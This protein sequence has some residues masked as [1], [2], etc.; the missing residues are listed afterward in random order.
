MLNRKINPESFDQLLRSY[1]PPEDRHGYPDSAPS[2]RPNEIWVEPET[3]EILNARPNPHANHTQTQAFPSHP[4][5]HSYPKD[6]NTMITK[7]SNPLSL[8]NAYQSYIPW[9]LMYAL[10]FILLWLVYSQTASFE[11]SLQQSLLSV[12]EIPKE[13]SAQKGQL[14]LVLEE[15]TILNERLDSEQEQMTK[16][17]PSEVSVSDKPIVKNSSPK[18]VSRS[19]TPTLPIKYLGTAMRNEN[20]QVLIESPAG[21]QFFRIGDLIFKG[22]RL[23]AIESQKLLLTNADGHQQIIPLTKSHP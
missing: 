12:G 16:S 8:D 18:K 11:Q 5:D 10:Q 15:I 6:F 1:Q 17:K 9:V 2:T 19:S 23:S 13:L 22:W 3:G 14:G 4:Q 21:I 7:S 20:H